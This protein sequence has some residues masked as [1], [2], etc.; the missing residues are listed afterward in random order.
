MEATVIIGIKTEIGFNSYVK[1]I[2]ER[3]VKKEGRS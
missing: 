2:A 1:F 3:K